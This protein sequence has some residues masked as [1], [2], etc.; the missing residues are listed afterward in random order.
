MHSDAWISVIRLCVALQGLPP[1]HALVGVLLA[2]KSS[3]SPRQTG[4][5]SH[6][7]PAGSFPLNQDRNTW[8]RPGDGDHA[9]VSERVV[10]D[11]SP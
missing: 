8:D 10:R 3:R 6:S 5:S 4:I 1:A 7:L 9:E 11:R 2:F